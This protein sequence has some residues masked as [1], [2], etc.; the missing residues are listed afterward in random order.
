MISRAQKF[1]IAV[2]LL[3]LPLASHAAPPK[4]TNAAPLELEHAKSTFVIPKTPADGRDPF[5]PKA[6]SIYQTDAPVKPVV[7]S[8]VNLLKLNGI[9]GSS[10]AQINNVTLSIGET[11]EVKTTSG[12]VAVRLIEIHATDGSVVVEASGQR[13]VLSFNTK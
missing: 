8:G 9:L 1:S 12:N 5:F 13:R 4:A 3:A 7:D 11:E 6:T 2:A 10:L